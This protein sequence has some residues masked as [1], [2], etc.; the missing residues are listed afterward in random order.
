MVYVEWLRVRGVLKWTV[1]VLGA[2]L[3]IAVVARIAL[4]GVERQAYGRVD[5]MASEKG[6]TVVEST[7]P[8]GARRTTIDNRT[9]QFH[10]VI[11]DYGWGHKRIT[12]LDLSDRDSGHENVSAGSIHIQTLPSGRGS[13]TVIDTDQPQGFGNFAISGVFIA[14]IVATILGAPFARENES[15]LEIAFTRPASRVRLGL[16][17]MGA[18]A[19]GMAFAFLLG[20]AWS[21]L[22]TTLF[23]IPRIT[24]DSGDALAIALGIC[25]PWAW[26][27]MLNAA[28]A[29]TKRGYGAMLGFAWPVALIIVLGLELWSPPAGNLGLQAFH[30]VAR[31]LSYIDP[32]SYVR[33][34]VVAVDGKSLI[35]S[36]AMR[37]ILALLGLTVVYSALALFE[38]KRVEA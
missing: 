12:V 13:L 19:A 33:F 35:Q 17:T 21:L 3:L 11:D 20:T 16:L 25:A 22:A 31:A 2:L 34:S 1:I 9:K 6:S 14:L 30:D 28:T 10:V 23:Q 36:S 27:A 18:D 7:A 8:D 5:A 38:W 29:W 32:F 37:E 15:H 24:F 4:I 26:Y